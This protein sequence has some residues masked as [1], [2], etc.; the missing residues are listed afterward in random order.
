MTFLVS[1]FSCPASPRQ[2]EVASVSG[3]R[4]PQGSQGRGFGQASPATAAGTELLSWAL[5]FPWLQIWEIVL[6]GP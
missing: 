4:G 1:L 2:A 6:K 5:L 3:K